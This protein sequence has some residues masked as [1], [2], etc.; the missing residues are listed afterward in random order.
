MQPCLSWVKLSAEG[1]DLAQVFSFYFLKQILQFVFLLLIL[2]LL[3]IK[4]G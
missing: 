3:V 1:R 2:F 4:I